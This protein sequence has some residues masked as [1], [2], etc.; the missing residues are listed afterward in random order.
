MTSNVGSQSILDPNMTEEGKREAV[1]EALKERFRPEFLNRIDEIVM[2][3]SLGEGQISGIVKVQLDHVAQRLRAKKINIEFSDDAVAWL[4]KKG[5]DPI[6]GARPLKRVIQNELLNPLSKE[7]IANKIRS[8]DTVKVTS[9]PGG[10]K[11]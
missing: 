11:F 2:F 7:I 4:A 3:R 1:N 9:G 5:Y 10:L 8:G 6:Y